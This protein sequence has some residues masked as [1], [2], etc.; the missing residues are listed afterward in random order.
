[1][2][3]PFEPLNF[4]IGFLLA[5]IALALAWGKNRKKHPYFR[6]V[7]L[8]VGFTFY[9]IREL[10]LANVRVAYYTLAPL[11]NLRPG[12][13]AIPLD[14]GMNDTGLTFLANTV[15]L[16]P[17]TLTLDFSSD[18]STM[19]VHFMHIDNAEEMKAEIKEGFERRIQEIFT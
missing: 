18:R 3:G 11:K 15:S 8:S 19:F 9:F 14:G 10:V 17:G 7:L 4:V 13:L 6:K 5:Y 2:F 1:M 12:I 16:T